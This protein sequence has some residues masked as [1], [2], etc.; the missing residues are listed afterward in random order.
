MKKYIKL[1]D[2]SLPYSLP[3]EYFFEGTLPTLTYLMI[4]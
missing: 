1:I 4:D 3:L 2:D